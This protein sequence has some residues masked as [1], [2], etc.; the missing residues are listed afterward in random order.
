MIEPGEN[1]KVYQL[2]K[3]NFDNDVLQVGDVVEDILLPQPV[4]LENTD[5][6]ARTHRF[7]LWRAMVMEIDFS[8]CRKIDF[9]IPE[10]TVI[11]PDDERVIDYINTTYMPYESEL[12]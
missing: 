1:R 2:W 7:R 5:W 10:I 6:Y 11:R 9:G 8:Y 4:S 12:K 3:K